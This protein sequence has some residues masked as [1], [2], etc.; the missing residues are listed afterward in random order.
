MLFGRSPHR[1]RSLLTR[2]GLFC[3]LCV[4]VPHEQQ[5]RPIDTRA[6]RRGFCPTR[7]LSPHHYLRVVAAV[8][9]GE[10]E[11]GRREVRRSQHWVMAARVRSQWQRPD[12]E[13][14]GG[15]W[16]GGERDCA[17]RLVFDAY[18]YCQ[19]DTTCRCIWALSC[20]LHMQMHAGKADHPAP[21]PP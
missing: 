18:V 9:E 17:R 2:T 21:P 13:E 16:E 6:T 8:A 7:R 12:G 19:F 5:A 3:H 14:R 11:E 4:P 20:V 1:N 15:G 10:R